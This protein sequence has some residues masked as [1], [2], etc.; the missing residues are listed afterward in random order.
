MKNTHSVIAGCFISL[1]LTTNVWAEGPHFAE[2]ILTIPHVNVDFEPGHFVDVQFKLAADGRWDLMN[3]TPI[4]AWLK[5]LIDELKAESVA[6]PPAQIIQYTY[7][8]A[9]VYYL[10]PKC[11]DIM[12]VLYDVEGNVLCSPDGGLT[13]EGD[14]RCPDF[15]ETATE[16]VVI[17]RDDR[18]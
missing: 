9:T 2:D 17:W 3:A 5:V 18:S 16:E 13:G 14:G 7:N 8:G 1:A 12:S 15:A 6:N 11:C 10:P 4:P